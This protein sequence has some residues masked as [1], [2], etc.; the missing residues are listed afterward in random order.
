[1]W[2][3]LIE[4]HPSLGD[5]RHFVVVVVVQG[6]DIILYSVLN[7]GGLFMLQEIP[8]PTCMHAS[9]VQLSR[10]NTERKHKRRVPAGENWGIRG[11]KD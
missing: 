1:M 6:G 10:A 5:Y 3:G 7:S 2:G 9:L 4:F 8:S 11:K